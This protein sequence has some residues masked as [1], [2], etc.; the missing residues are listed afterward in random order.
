[1]GGAGWGGIGMTSCW[2]EVGI[3]DGVFWFCGV[4]LLGVLGAVELCIC[5]VADSFILFG[6][7]ATV[8][9]LRK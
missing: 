3:A 2:C 8:V 5:V 9:A 6:L 7:E 1:M 4:R